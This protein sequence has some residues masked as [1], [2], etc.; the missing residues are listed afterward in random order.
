MLGDDQSI[1]IQMRGGPEPMMVT[2]WAQVRRYLT[3]IKAALIIKQKE[4]FYF[5]RSWLLI[6]T[7][8]EPI[9]VWQAIAR[10]RSMLLQ[11]WEFIK[12]TFDL[13]CSI[14]CGNR[15]SDIFAFK[16]IFQYIDKSHEIAL[17]SCNGSKSCFAKYAFFKNVILFQISYFLLKRKYI[18]LSFNIN[19]LSSI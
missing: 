2:S 14:F 18:F 5:S 17:G 1:A 8:S 11:M 3:L 9:I 15:S 16:T 19:F 4:W 6:L 12:K 10:A 13:I 7:T